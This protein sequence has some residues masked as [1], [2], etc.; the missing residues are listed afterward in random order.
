MGHF[1]LQAPTRE[2][3]ERKSVIPAAAYAD[4]LG[5]IMTVLSVL[6]GSHRSEGDYCWCF[7]FVIFYFAVDWEDTIS[8]PRKL[9]G[10]KVSWRQSSFDV[11]RQALH[12]R[13][14]FN[15]TQEVLS[16]IFYSSLSHVLVA[17]NLDRQLI[18]A[19]PTCLS[20]GIREHFSGLKDTPISHQGIG[21]QPVCRER[22]TPKSPDHPTAKESFQRS[23][24]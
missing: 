6:S 2:L 11:L 15:T 4:P 17:S 13:Y 19:N 8:L 12:R 3:V 10:L 23:R 18:P 22:N 9:R 24:D 14:S 5:E 21:V 7:S 20:D 16:N 1:F